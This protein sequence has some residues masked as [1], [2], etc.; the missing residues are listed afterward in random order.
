[1][2]NSTQ[3]ARTPLPTALPPLKELD[4]HARYFSSRTGGDFFD[5]VAAGPHV[6]FLLTD[7]AGSRAEAH[8]IAS[9]AQDVFRL[10]VP[11]L[12]SADV[13]NMMD[14]LGI[15]AHEVNQAIYTTAGGSRLAPT[16][17]GCYNLPL[18]LL[19]YINSGGP[20]AIFRDSDGTRILGHVTMPLGLF[21]HLTFEPA[22]QAFEPGARLLLVTKGILEAQR[23]REQF[24]VERATAVLENIPNNSAFDLC[25]IVLEDAH[26]FR[27]PPW[28]SPERLPFVKSEPPDDLTA[29]ALV[30]PR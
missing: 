29:V 2:Q 28:Y 18:G 1:M 25:G 26:E 10:R 3:S 6:V 16:F 27:K 21:T 7:I 13:I 12:F 24:G 30:R 5:A 19:A 8:T 4:L 17:L 20:P 23:G 22:I 14:T 15:L 11:Q 9:A